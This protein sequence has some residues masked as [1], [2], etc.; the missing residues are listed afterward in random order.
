[1]D[2]IQA[3]VDHT[4]DV[5]TAAILASYVS[6]ARFKDEK[7][8]IWV[9]A[10]RD[11]L[12]SWGLFHYRSQFDIERGQMTQHMIS[13]GEIPPFEWVE[14]QLLIRC[15]NCNK[16]INATNPQTTLP[17]ERVTVRIFPFPSGPF[18]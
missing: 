4:S 13:N 15:N 7:V 2:V 11:L 1:M 3:Y 18:G 16:T 6:P 8:Q 10:Y 14:K 12:D 17:G 5:Q 9:E